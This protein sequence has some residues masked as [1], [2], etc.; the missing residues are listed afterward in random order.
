[1]KDVKVEYVKLDDSIVFYYLMR[2]LKEEDEIVLVGGDGTVNYFVNAI[3]GIL[4]KN[5]VYLKTNGHANDF[6]NDIEKYKG[7]DLLITRE[8]AVQCILGH[9]SIV[10]TMSGLKSA[11]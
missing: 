9:G 5:N 7:K 3:D 2:S 6:I 8:Q 4:L 10:M 11:D 1:M